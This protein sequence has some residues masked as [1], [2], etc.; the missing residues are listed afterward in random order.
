MKWMKVLMIDA[1]VKKMC[2]RLYETEILSSHFL[3]NRVVGLQ[4][5]LS[6]YLMMDWA[7]YSNGFHDF[8]LTSLN[9]CAASSPAFKNVAIKRG[10][11]ETYY[12]EREFT[13]FTVVENWEKFLRA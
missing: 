7:F 3:K 2:D 5:V 10:Y 11:G 6:Y 13:S 9:C 12:R 1:N 8:N 4:H